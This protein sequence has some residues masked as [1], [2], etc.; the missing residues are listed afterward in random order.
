M[1]TRPV[2]TDIAARETIERAERASMQRDGTLALE[3]CDL[4]SELTRAG[5]RLFPLADPSAI[6]ARPVTLRARYAGSCSACGAPIAID[7]LISFT[8]ERPGVRCAACGGNG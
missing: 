3:A 4:L 1:T 5:Y 6:A 8:R 7:D 2:R